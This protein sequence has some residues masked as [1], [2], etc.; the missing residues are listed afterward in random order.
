MHGV[1]T[2]CKMK[3]AIL[4]AVWLASITFHIPDM[5]SSSA[6]AA[7][8]S[9]FFSNIHILNNFFSFSH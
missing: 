4:A 7:A 8:P 9:K 2:H 3:L 6:A 5:P 1:I